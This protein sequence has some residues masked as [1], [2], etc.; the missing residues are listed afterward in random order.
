[1]IKDGDLVGVVFA[2]LSGLVIDDVADEGERIRVRARSREAPVRCPGCDV[3]TSCVHGW[4]ERTVADL[5]VDGRPVLLEVRVRRLTCRN[6]QCP[7]RTFREQI[8]GVLE[9]YQRRTARLAAPVGA[10]VRELAGRADARVLTLLGVP[11]SRHTALRTLLRLPLPEVT[12][13]R[14]LGVDDFALR[15]SHSYATVLIDAETRRRVDVLPDRRSGTLA[16]WLR[17]HPGVEVVCRDGAA[18]YADAVHQA[19]PGALQVGDRWHIWHNFAQAASKEVAVHSGCWASASRVRKLDGG[20]TTTLARWHQV[21]DLLNAGV[22][23]LECARRLDL[24]LNTV[25]RYARID[26]VLY[27]YITQ[28]RVEDD[29][30]GLSPRRLARLL[31]ARPG[32]LKPDQHELLAKTT[33]ACPEMSALAALVRT[34]AHLLTPAAENA[35]RL[36]EWITAAQE[37]KLP[38]VH[39]FIRGLRLDHDAVCA[40]LT[41]EYH[42][43]GTEGVNTKTKLIKRQMYGRAGFRLLRHRIL[44]G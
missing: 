17:E 32:T 13:P 35:D 7:R 25:K 8:M 11:V 43:G 31:L 39:S 12:P 18:G 33:S 34:F 1:M 10:V 29:R 2:G 38:H 44:L 3:E 27:R 14:V 15:R 42:N 5:P 36:Q 41:S 4:C 23:L 40:A 21:H 24:A 9:R 6:R 37:V 22:G 16:A 19:L 20:K 26:A 30:P 28:G